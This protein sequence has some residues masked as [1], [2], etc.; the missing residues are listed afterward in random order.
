[1]LRLILIGLGVMGKNHYRV[2][3]TLPNVEVVALCDAMMDE[4]EG[5][6]VYRTVDEA[7]KKV[8]ADAALIAVPTFLHKEV[9]LK[10]IA[11]GLHIFIEKP[12]AATVQEASD[13]SSA[14]PSKIHSAVGHIER[15]NPVVS[16]LKNELEGKDIYSIAITRV[17]PFPPRIADVGI[18]TDLAVHDVDLIRYI[19]AKEILDKHIFA[20][21]KI[22]NHHEDNA[23]LSFKLES[24]VVATITTNWLT[25]YKKRK[26]EVATPA[27][28]YEADLISQDLRVYSAYSASHSYLVRDVIVQK[29][30]PL[31]NELNAFINLCKTGDR[32]GL[33]TIE[34][35][36]K[37]LELVR[38]EER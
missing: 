32:A 13:I 37:T 21:Q 26:I 24:E 12:A 3:K 31:R 10:C 4:F 9:A 7:L 16:A 2:L 1:M 27:G 25:P 35:S 38:F 15:F 22:H 17:G 20:S 8:E 14:I 5:K 18:L 11:K 33:A 36:I 30:E 29:G 6:K 34:D 28:Y 23:I 19:T